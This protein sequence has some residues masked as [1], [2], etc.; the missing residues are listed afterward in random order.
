MVVKTTIVAKIAECVQNGTIAEVADVRDESDRHGLRI[1]VELK[2]EADPEVALNKLYRY[3]PLQST[4]AIANIA[5]VNNR[6]E[7]LNIR[8]ML[9]C[10]LEHRKTVVRRRSRF[11]LKRCRTRAHIVEGLLLAHANLDE[12]I[13]VIRSSATQAEAKRRLRELEG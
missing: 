11:L 4:F 7:T 10:F 5:L 6:P 13:R 9:D 1:V 12:V 8:E 2:K 3:T